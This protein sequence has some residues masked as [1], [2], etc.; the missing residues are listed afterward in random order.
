MLLQGWDIYFAM[1]DNPVKLTSSEFTQRRSEDSEFL[2]G[3][4][5]R[6]CH[7]CVW[8]DPTEEEG[9]ERARAGIDQPHSDYTLRLVS[10]GKEL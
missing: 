3:N 10:S 9:G 2:H 1:A 6:R 8:K 7:D 5:K 4:V